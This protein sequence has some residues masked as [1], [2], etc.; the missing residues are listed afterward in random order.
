MVLGLLVG[1]LF[2]RICVSLVN[3]ALCF[4]PHLQPTQLPL[5]PFGHQFSQLAVLCC[6]VMARAHSWQKLKTQRFHAELMCSELLAATPPAAKILQ[7]SHIIQMYSL[8]VSYQ[9]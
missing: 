7:Y 8:V 2:A 9:V 3:P 5:G 6:T 4:T 1:G